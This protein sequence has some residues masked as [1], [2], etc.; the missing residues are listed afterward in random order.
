V[1]LWKRSDSQLAEI[2]KDGPMTRPKLHGL[3]RNLAVALG[4]SG[5]SEA[6]D[7]LDHERSDRSIQNPLVAEHVEWAKRKLQT[8]RD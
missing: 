3:R 4:N 5:T 7:A 2:V 8:R 1:D 6:A